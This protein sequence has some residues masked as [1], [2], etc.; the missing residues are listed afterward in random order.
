MRLKLSQATVAH[1]GVNAD[2]TLLLSAHLFT[3][4]LEME[5]I[6][7]RFLMAAACSAALLMSTAAF[8]HGGSGPHGGGGHAWHG[9][10]GGWHGGPGGHGGWHGPG[11]GW[12]GGPG[13]NRG[14]DRGHY[15]G[16]PW[17]W[18]YPGAFVWG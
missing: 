18:V 3:R 7:K 2:R 1:S 15:W 9:G 14:W 4:K 8:A 10:G 13:W 12:H 16:S 11:G 6:M 17:Y 5:S